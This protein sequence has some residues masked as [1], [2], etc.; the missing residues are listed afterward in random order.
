MDYYFSDGWKLLFAIG[1]REEYD[2]IDD[3]Q[4]GEFGKKFRLATHPNM[5][6]RY[7]IIGSNSDAE[8]VMQLLQE[9]SDALSF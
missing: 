7:V 9:M 3:D 8:L 2:R 4:Y 6:R 5:N 1:K